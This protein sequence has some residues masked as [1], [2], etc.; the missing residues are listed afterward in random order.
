MSKFQGEKASLQSIYNLSIYSKYNLK[1][2]TIKK[3]SLVKFFTPFS[4]CNLYGATK[5][6]P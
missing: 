1:G 6:T 4:F 3:W 5:T 2:E